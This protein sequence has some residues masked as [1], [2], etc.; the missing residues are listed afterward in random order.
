MN[1]L[2]ELQRAKFREGEYELT[3]YETRAVVQDFYGLM[4][5]DALVL[6]D[7]TY[8]PFRHSHAKWR[9]EYD[10]YRAN[11]I[12]RLA[13][14]IYD[15]TVTVVGGELRHGNRQSTHY[16]KDLSQGGYRAEYYPIIHRYNPTDILR[17]GVANFACEWADDY[18]GEL[19]K[20]IAQAGLDREKLGDLCFIDHCVDLSHNSCSYFDKCSSKI[21]RLDSN[22]TYKN[23]LDFKRRCT[24]TELL[25]SYN[26]SS[27]LRDFVSRAEVLGITNKVVYYK[28]EGQCTYYGVY[29][30][31]SY[32]EKLIKRQPL[33]WGTRELSPELAESQ[34]YRGNDRRRRDY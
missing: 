14:L 25:C 9:R 27:Y 28:P 20:I 16:V 5:L 15:Y 3:A 1:Y 30:L 13:D 29:E 34:D 4:S 18:G 32:I 33:N 17:A 23:F 26:I 22:S 31:D 7:N 24:P 19:W 10:E 21:M 6:L 11:Y 12:K 2:A 8:E